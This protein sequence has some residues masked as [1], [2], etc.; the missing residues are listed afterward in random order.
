MNG[1]IIQNSKGILRGKGCTRPLLRIILDKDISE[2]LTHLDG[3]LSCFC[4]RQHSAFPWINIRLPSCGTLHGLAA[5][6]LDGIDV[7]ICVKISIHTPHLFFPASSWRMRAQSLCLWY[8]LKA[9]LNGN[10]CFQDDPSYF[11]C[12]DFL[13]AFEQGD[14]GPSS[15]H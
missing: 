8:S 11:P 4:I 7:G 1:R 14:H 12:R 5:L 15:Y 2:V 10:C 13:N 6:Y 9:V 3:A